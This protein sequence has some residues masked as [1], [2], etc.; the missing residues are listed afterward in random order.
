[1]T[2]PIKLATGDVAAALVD[3]HPD[4]HLVSGKLRR[5]LAFANFAAAF[6]FMAQ[7]AI[8]A[9][10]LDHHPEWSN[11]YNRVDVDL[12]THDAAGITELDFA[13]ARKIDDAAESS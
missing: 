1:M 9:E 5:E 2:R 8:H 7:I 10:A 4:W 11:V 12:V 3:L 6:G 13:L